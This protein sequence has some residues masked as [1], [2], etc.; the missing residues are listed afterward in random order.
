MLPCGRSCGRCC[1]ISP[2]PPW[3]W[4]IFWQI[5][6][7][8]GII[9]ILAGKTTGLEGLE[10]AL[11][12]S[13]SAI[14]LDVMLPGLNGFEVL[15]RLREKSN[16]PVLMLTARGGE[17]DRIAGLEVGACCRKRVRSGKRGHGE[18]RKGSQGG[19][20]LEARV[21]I[22]TEVHRTATLTGMPCWRR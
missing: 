18:K 1:A 7:T 14:I 3:A 20:K 5:G 4:A 22:C 21:E 19:K 17:A 8:V 12:E 11:R 10:M 16:V 2:L 13:W 15:K 6:L 9:G